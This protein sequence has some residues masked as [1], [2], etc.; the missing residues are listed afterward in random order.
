MLFYIF[1]CVVNVDVDA[2]D[3]VVVK[4]CTCVGFYL[5]VVVFFYGDGVN[6]IVVLL[7]LI[8]L[9]FS[10]IVNFVLFLFSFFSNE[11]DVFLMTLPQ[12]RF[13]NRNFSL[14]KYRLPLK[15]FFQI[16]KLQKFSKLPKF[17]CFEK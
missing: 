3:V 9:F 6:F 15:Y 4:R 17:F 2:D 1:C 10:I 7:F 14:A 12:H 16:F 11:T 8:F 5:F 13:I